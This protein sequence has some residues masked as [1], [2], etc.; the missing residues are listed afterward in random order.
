MNTG[1]IISSTHMST[2]LAY[3]DS[4]SNRHNGPSSSDVDEMLRVIG[5][6]SLDEL[7]KDSVPSSIFYDKPL[8]LDKPLS[9]YEFLERVQD[10][11]KENIIYRSFIGMGYYDTITPPVIQRNILENPSWYTQ[12]TPYQAEISQGRLEALLNFQTMVIDSNR[13]WTLP[14]HRFLDEGTA[15]AEAMMMFSRLKQEVGHKTLFFIDERCHP[16]TIDVVI[17]RAEPLGIEIVIGDYAAYELPE[18]LLARCCNI[19]LLMEVSKIMR[20]SASVCTSKTHTWQ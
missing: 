2:P 8:A 7:I 5:K 16:Q 9:E 20:P 13:D 17:T 3:T 15:A 19:R 4:F 14:M 1:N 12:Y 10:I 11:A 6:K 18:N